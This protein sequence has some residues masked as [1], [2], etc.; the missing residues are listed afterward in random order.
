MAQATEANSL[1][2]EPTMSDPVDGHGD[3]ISCDCGGGYNSSGIEEAPRPWRAA[4]ALNKLREQVNVTY[5]GRDKSHDGTIGDA[6]HQSRASDHNPWIVD[7]VNGVVSAIDIGHDPANGCDANEIVAALLASRDPRIKYVIWNRR[8]ANSAAIGSVPG[9][10]W[11]AYT[12][13]NPHNKHFHL[14]V[15][16]EKSRYDDRSEWTLPSIN[17]SVDL[18]ESECDSDVEVL[19]ALAVLGRGTDRSGPALPQLVAAQ[20]ALDR[21]FAYTRMSNEIAEAEDEIALEAASTDFASLKPNYEALFASAKV[22]AEWRDTVQ[23]YLAMVRKGRAKYEEVQAKTGTPW[24]FVGIVHGMEAG[25][26]FGGH[27]H[28]GDPLT[29]RTVQIPKNRP[30]VW[31]PPSDWLSSAVDAIEGEGYAGKTDWTLARALFRFERYNGFGYYAKGINSPYLW[32]FSNHYSQGKFIGDKKYSA[33]AVSK[34]CGAAVM[35][36]ALADAGDVAIPA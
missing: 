29:A 23:W 9:W 28:N 17:E 34:Q 18:E 7:G 12:G 1:P 10:T 24:W 26:R 15:K 6:A 35:L 36:R 32:S 11:R 5:P 19:D 33:T 25:F 30:A 14:S 31:N 2:D 3:G 21:L 20:E 27:L 8:I 13:A 22:R 4:E 16:A